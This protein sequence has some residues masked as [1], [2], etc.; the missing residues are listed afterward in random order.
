MKRND[1]GDSYVLGCSSGSL[2]RGECI[3]QKDDHLCW[4]ALCATVTGQPVRRTERLCRH[5]MEMPGRYGF[6]STRPAPWEASQCGVERRPPVQSKGAVNFRRTAGS[7]SLRNT[8]SALVATSSAALSSRCDQCDYCRSCYLMNPREYVKLRTYAPLFPFSA[9]PTSGLPT[10]TVPG[11]ASGRSR[12][13]HWSPDRK[14]VGNSV[15]RRS[16]S[17][18]IG[19]ASRGSNVQWPGSGRR[20]GRRSTGC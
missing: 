20:C 7:G 18:S 6:H 17:T 2:R 15:K 16:S 12:P 5:A 11:S 10:G 1:I 19:T 3:H 14:P 9:F 4:Q 13:T 8:A